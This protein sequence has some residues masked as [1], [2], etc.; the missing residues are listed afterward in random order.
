MKNIN[1]LEKQK[2]SNYN[3][4]KSHYADKWIAESPRGVSTQ[5]DSKKEAV[6]YASKR[7]LK[8]NFTKPL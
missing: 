2:V 5:H 7:A 1:S 8:I 4:R 6:E 3:I